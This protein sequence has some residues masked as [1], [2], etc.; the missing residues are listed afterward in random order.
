MVG[1]ILA[2]STLSLLSLVVGAGQRNA[3]KRAQCQ[4]VTVGQGLLHRRDEN[5]MLQLRAA[6]RDV[7][8]EVYQFSRHGSSSKASLCVVWDL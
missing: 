5:E 4:T 8:L 6:K 2:N 3:I 1:W 7:F